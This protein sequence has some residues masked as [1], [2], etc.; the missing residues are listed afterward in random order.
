MIKIRKFEKFDIEKMIKIWNEV[1]EEGKAFP[2]EEILTISNAFEFFNSQTYCGIAENESNQI[3]GLYIL[4]PNNIGRCSH[5]SNASYAVNSNFRGQGIGKLLVTDCLK[6][7]SIAGFKI[8]QFNAV[9]ASN[10]SAH[11][12]YKELG[13]I[14]LGSIPNGFR[15]KYSEYE[16]IVLYYHLL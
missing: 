13:F 15:N 10:L 14:K 6:Q 7:A 8:L 4:H 9:V 12:L 1:V 11:H 5:I 16:D 3:L 2:Q